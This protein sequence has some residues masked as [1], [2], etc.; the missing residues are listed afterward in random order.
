MT[1][2]CNRAGHYIFIL[3]CLLL[4]VY[5]S[6]FFPRLISAVTD[7]M[8]AIL[9]HMVWPY[10]EFKM[11]V[12]N[13]LHIARCKYRTQKIVRNLPSGHHRTTLLGYICATK[14]HIDNWKKNLLSSN[15]SSTYPHKMMN[16]GALAA[17]I[18]PV[19]WGTPAN[20]SG[21][22]VLAALRHGTPALG[23]RQTLRCWTEGT[24]YIW[25]GGHHVGHRPTF[26]FVDLLLWC[27]WK[28]QK[29]ILEEEWDQFMAT[30]RQPLPSTFRITGSRRSVVHL[31]V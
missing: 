24:T 31:L 17:E 3:W 9:P 16:F 22:C 20:F 25:Q 8:S 23:V 13:M 10:C 30:L 19:V 4:S 21:F 26:W 2:L 12:W 1:A 14:A 18:G 28:G 5:L 6:I 15:I 29:L 7:W 27:V 11:Q